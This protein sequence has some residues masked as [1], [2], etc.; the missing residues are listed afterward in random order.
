MKADD[1]IRAYMVIAL[2]SAFVYLALTTEG[3][4]ESLITLA[5]SAVSY[6]VGS[7]TGSKNKD[8]ALA[9]KETT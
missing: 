6:Y 2:V 9:K 3:Y 7:S 8:Q 4:K 5:A 1:L